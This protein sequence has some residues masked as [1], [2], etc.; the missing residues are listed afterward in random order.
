M[1]FEQ[2]LA[3]VLLLLVLLLNFVLPMFRRR[4]EEEVHQGAGPV[5]PGMPA[6]RPTSW[7]GERTGRLPEGPRIVPMP[8]A[9]PVR[10][11]PA[12]PVTLREARRGVLLMTI[13]G[14]CRAS[15]PPGT[16]D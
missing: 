5:P 10:R 6:W 15:D 14:P 7:Q 1:T 11:R 13:L 4:L 8:L 2:V 16:P 9:P 3:V 12:R